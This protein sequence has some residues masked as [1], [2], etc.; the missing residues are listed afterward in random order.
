MFSVP[1][2]SEKTVARLALYRRLLVVLVIQGR[3]SIDSHER[4]GLAKVSA[5]VVR[6]DL[7]AVGYEGS[8][9][10][11]YAIDDLVQALSHLLDHPA[12]QKVALVGVGNLGRALL[13]YF[14]GRASQYSVAAAF[15]A[16]PGKVGHAVNGCPVY[17]PDRLAEMI[18]RDG[19]EVAIV[20]VPAGD[21]Q[22]TVHDL[23]GAGITG[24]L[25]FAPVRVWVP[26]GLYIEYLDMS[27][28]LERVAFFARSKRRGSW[29]HTE[30][31]G[32][33]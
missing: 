16:D 22:R 12:T 3:R 11:G 1:V 31:A 32:R 33:E 27:M 26:E 4:A 8:P 9:T 21:A 5:A 15:D 24:I 25:N 14:A 10:R 30:G 2:I 18:E 6:R 17:A 13:S 7:M 29:S 28:S 20:A 23:C 19:I